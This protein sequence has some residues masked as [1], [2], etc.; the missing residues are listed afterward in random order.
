[1][2][3]N[4][5]NFQ[6]AETTERWSLALSSDGKCTVQWANLKTG[7]VQSV[8]PPKPGFNHSK[9]T[10]INYLE[11]GTWNRDPCTTLYPKRRGSKMRQTSTVEMTSILP[12]TC[13]F[14]KDHFIFQLEELCKKLFYY[15]LL[16]SRLH[17]TSSD[18]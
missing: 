1:M 13:P 14:I 9:L 10:D 7:R 11:G 2:P 12:Q 4:N 18:S 15:S 17:R 3:L 5:V 16:G 6:V 8:L